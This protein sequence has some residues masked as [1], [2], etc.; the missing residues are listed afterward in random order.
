LAFFASDLDWRQQTLIREVDCARNCTICPSIETIKMVD[1]F[2][3][4]HFLRNTI[5]DFIRTASV[6]VGKCDKWIVFQ[7][8]MADT[9]DKK[10]NLYHLTPIPKLHLNGTIEILDI[11]SPY[12]GINDELNMYFNLQNLDDCLKMYSATD[13]RID[14][15]VAPVSV[16][17]FN[18]NLGT[19]IYK[20]SI[21]RKLKPKIAI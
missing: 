19:F 7:Y 15:S 20:Y 17:Q 4:T 8:T 9:W 12:V 13:P 11:E 10:C 16:T 14:E 6:T 5:S 1:K 21:K 18:N 3:I 2:L